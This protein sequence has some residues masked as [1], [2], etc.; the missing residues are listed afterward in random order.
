MISGDLL[1]FERQIMFLGNLCEVVLLEWLLERIVV[2]CL[3][4]AG[5][6][7]ICFDITYR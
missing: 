6:D 5:D 7:R 1:V 4:G 2:T 3:L